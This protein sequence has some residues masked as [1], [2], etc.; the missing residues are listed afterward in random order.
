MIAYSAPKT[1]DKLPLIDLRASF[2][3]DPA[4]RIGVALEIRK[5]V[6]DTGFLYVTNHGVDQAI[7]DAAFEQGRRF[8]DLPLAVKEQYAR[9]RGK[10]GYEGLEGQAVDR[11]LA[12]GERS[13]PDYKE[14]YNFGRDRGPV[15]PNFAENQWPAE[16]AGFREP[17]EAYY[18]AVDGLAYHLVRM[19]ALSLELDEHAFDPAFEYAHGTCRL[20]R[21]PPQPAN[22]KRNQMGAGAHT[23]IGAITILAQD[24]RQALE[25]LHRSGDWIK[26]EPI[27][28]TFVVNIADMFP[29]WTNDIYR[30]SMH[31]VMNNASGR[32]RHSIVFFYSPNYYTEIACVPTCLAPGER[33][34]YEPIVAG[35]YARARLAASRAHATGEATEY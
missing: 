27:R 14:S 15:S 17:L 26:A 8:L 24:D 4:A 11:T 6:T 3:A 33:P 7:V 22:A 13:A 18:T 25:V 30:S 21:Y 10:R 16:L 9:G 5:A 1:A 28:G 23:D 31:R 32:D 20:L 29:R 2:S 12:G 34:K 19:L 35:E